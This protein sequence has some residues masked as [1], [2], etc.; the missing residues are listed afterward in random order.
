MQIP[1]NREFTIEILYC[2]EIFLQFYYF[3]LFWT[4]SYLFSVPPQLTVKID[5]QVPIV[6]GTDVSMTCIV[7]SNPP[8]AELEWL[9]DGASLG[10]AVKRDT[11]N[12][13]LN[14][15]SVGP[16]HKGRY[17]CAGI[18]SEGRSIS[19]PEYL[20]IHCKFWFVCY[21]VDVILSYSLDYLKVVLH[22]A[23]RSPLFGWQYSAT[24][25]GFMV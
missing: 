15:S 6:E 22:K 24:S 11:R 18:N 14:I 5:K 9:K 16:D 2:M 20:K 7:H 4:L 12:R 19:E 17:Q 10:P 25:T 1:C 13:T 8:I 21:T 23:T 3:I